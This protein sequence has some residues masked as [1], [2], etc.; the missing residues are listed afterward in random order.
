MNLFY[1]G[2]LILLVLYVCVTDSNVPDYIIMKIKLLQLDIIKC[3]W[4]IK[5][6]YELKNLKKFK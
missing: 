5:L 3:I 6:K 1:I 4:E 2:L